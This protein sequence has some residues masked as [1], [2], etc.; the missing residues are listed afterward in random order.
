MTTVSGK[1]FQMCI[2][3]T[4]KKFKC[5]LWCGDERGLS[6]IAVLYN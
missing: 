6:L 4:E 3:L 1:E 5:K 2:T